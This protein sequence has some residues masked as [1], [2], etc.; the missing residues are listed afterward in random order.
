[1]EAGFYVDVRLLAVEPWAAWVIKNLYSFSFFFLIEYY[2]IKLMQNKFTLLELVKQC[3]CIG[4]IESLIEANGLY[5][6]VIDGV[7]VGQISEPDAKILGQQPDNPFVIDSTQHTATFKQELGDQQSRSEAI[8]RLLNRMRETKAWASLAKW[9]NELYPVYNDQ[10][11]ISV[12][13]ER[14]ACSNFGLRTYGVHIN[15]ITRVDGQLMMWIGKR[16]ASKPT[17][18]GM[19]DQ[20]VAGGIGNG[21]GVWESVLKECD[22]EASV[23]LDIAQKNTKCAG[24]IQYHHKTEFG[25]QPE[26]Q[27]VFDL[28]LPQ[29][30]KPVPNDGEVESFT[31]LSMDKVIDRLKQGQF[32]PNCAA[33]AID[34][35]IRHGHVTPMNEPDY[36]RIIENLHRS[37]P[38]PGPIVGIL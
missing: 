9:R 26:T 14:A 16:S 3:N 28:E 24:A 33:C 12:M 20:L 27:Y 6:F 31:L 36:L 10:G 21:A 13:M 7:M 1:M 29:D 37:L 30:F 19:L 5:Q 18:P 2:F 4:N 34:F 15:G 17:W 11:G 22:E 32:K 38:Y 23:P 25:L 8:A 35:L